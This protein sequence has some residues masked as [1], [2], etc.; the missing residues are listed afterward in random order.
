MFVLVRALYREG[1]L[2]PGEPPAQAGQ[3]F[4]SQEAGALLVLDLWPLTWVQNA[5]DVSGEALGRLWQPVLSGVQYREFV[6]RG[7]EAVSQGRE[8]R[9]FLQKWVCEVVSREQAM[10]LQPPAAS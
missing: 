10:R 6:L 5:P 7:Y 4:S 9:W 3:L 2:L 8:R 1:R